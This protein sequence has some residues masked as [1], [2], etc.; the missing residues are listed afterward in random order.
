MKYPKILEEKLWL[1]KTPSRHLYKFEIK[2]GK[3]K[4][5]VIHNKK[6][7]KKVLEKYQPLNCYYTICEYLY[8]KDLEN[9]WQT[10]PLEPNQEE[11]ITNKTQKSFMKGKF[12]QGKMLIDYDQGYEQARIINKKLKNLK[13]TKDYI[14]QTRKGR[15]QEI[16]N[17]P[18]NH[19]KKIKNSKRQGLNQYIKKIYEEHLTKHNIDQTIKKNQSLRIGRLPETPRKI[20]KK[21]ETTH[22]IVQQKV[23]ELR[24]TEKFND[25]NTEHKKTEAARKAAQPTAKIR[26]YT[27]N[28][29]LGTKNSYIL[30]LKLKTKTQ[31]KTLKKIM[32]RWNIKKAHIITDKKNL[33]LIETKTQN[34]QRIKKILIKEQ[35]IKKN[36]KYAETLIPTT[37]EIT[38]NQGKIITLNTKPKWKKTLTEGKQ[39]PK[40][41]NSEQHKKLI[42]HYK[43]KKVTIKTKI[44]PTKINKKE[45]EELK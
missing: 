14:L 43:G 3:W 15:F 10:H 32:K 13:L 8:P 38:T 29:I 24:K 40:T 30:I 6:Q 36:K 41:K 27:T 37:K 45:K 28:K 7:L 19:Y 18:N 21:W 4:N 39:N 1:P 11:P 5:F 20:R 34:K 42:K 31:E 17:I 16:W 23:G 35:Q 33:Y 26:G 22:I 25:K 2:E 12:L 9:F 44:I